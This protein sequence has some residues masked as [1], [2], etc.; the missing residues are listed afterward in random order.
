MKLGDKVI[1]AFKN[2]DA[3][4]MSLVIPESRKAMA[5]ES[6]WLDNREKIAKKFRQAAAENTGLPSLKFQKDVPVFLKTTEKSRMTKTQY[7]EREIVTVEIIKPQ[8]M[9]ENPPG[10]RM[11]MWVTQEVFR[12][13]MEPFRGPEGW[14]P[15]DTELCVMN[16]GKLRGKR[17]S[18]NDYYIGSAEQ[19]RKL[20]EM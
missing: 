13:R 19:G 2:A 1:E 20:A 18:Y 16:L 9:E 8:T 11:T 17:F 3:R 12:T 15:A 14:I 10:T 7:G 4:D 5:K 6:Y